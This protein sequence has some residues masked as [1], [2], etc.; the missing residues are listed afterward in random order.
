MRDGFIPTNGTVKPPAR[1]AGTV[2][3]CVLDI[4][5]SPMFF[6]LSIRTAF[7]LIPSHSFEPLSNCKFLLAS[8]R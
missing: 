4:S 5:Q 2:A 7:Q 8:F 1:H 6:I 3:A